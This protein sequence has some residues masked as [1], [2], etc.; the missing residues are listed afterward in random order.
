MFE[1]INQEIPRIVPINENHSVNACEVFYIVQL[2]GSDMSKVKRGND[3]EVS[4]WNWRAWIF[5]L[6][7][8]IVKNSKIRNYYEKIIGFF[9][10]YIFEHF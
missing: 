9:L 2:F 3:K 8:K 5:T 6:K 1:F 7:K 10:I 4:G